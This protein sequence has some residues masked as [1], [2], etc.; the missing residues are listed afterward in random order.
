[1]ERRHSAANKA[2]GRDA[3]DNLSAALS[4]ATADATG[5]AGHAVSPAVA[6]DKALGDD[7]DQVDGNVP[8]PG[9][10][11]N[12]IDLFGRAKLLSSFQGAPNANERNRQNCSEYKW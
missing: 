8:R 2:T 11:I 9:R 12:K 4:G 7:R 10:C 3:T 6:H 1:M 5:R